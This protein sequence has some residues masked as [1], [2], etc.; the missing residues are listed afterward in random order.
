MKCLLLTVTL[1]GLLAILQAQDDLPF[2]SDENKLSGVWFL[3]ATVSQ[4]RRTEGQTAAA[5]PHRFTC[6]EE[7]ILELR[8]TFMSE[9]QCIKTLLRMQRTKEP[10]QYSTFFGH[11]LFYIYELPVKDHYIIYMEGV[12]F[13]KKFQEGYL[14]GK[15]PEEN[16]EALEEFKEFI[17]RKG[18]LQE[19]IIVPE[20]RERCVPI[21]DSAHQDHKC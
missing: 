20:Q 15:C 11:N 14:I 17:Q 18:L 5:F 8:N 10:G 6:P 2:L 19:N 13:E 3:K 21:H 1:F 12:L 4:R 9:G 16:L 7:G